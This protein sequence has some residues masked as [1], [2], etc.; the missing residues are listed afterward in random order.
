MT[1]L[2]HDERD[3]IERGGTLWCMRM[4]AQDKWQIYKITWENEEILPVPP[5][6]EFQAALWTCMLAGLAESHGKVALHHAVKRPMGE[7][8]FPVLEQPETAP[9]SPSPMRRPMERRR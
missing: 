6:S 3:F 7:T 8:R 1:Q 5:T 4:V 9:T 2:T